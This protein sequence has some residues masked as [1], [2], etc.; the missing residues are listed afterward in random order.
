M[1]LINLILN[2]KQKTMN[3]IQK[4]QHDNQVL[5]NGIDIAINELIEYQ[6]YY[7][8]DKFKGIENDFAHI[9]TDVYA[10]ITTIKM[11]LQ[12]TLNKI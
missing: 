12:L 10:K 3:H 5:K 6:K 1:F 7:S 8:L 4:L 11:F 9:S 2:P